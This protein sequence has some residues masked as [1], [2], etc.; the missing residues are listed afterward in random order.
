MFQDL[1]QKLDPYI[2]L[3]TCGASL[4]GLMGL[5]LVSAL[6]IIAQSSTPKVDTS[7]TVPLGSETA[8]V[9]NMSTEAVPVGNLSADDMA[10]QE[11]DKVPEV[12]EPEK[13]HE[14]PKGPIED[15]IAGLHENTPQG[16]VP[17]IRKSDGLTAY[18]AYKA[19]FEAL[20]TTK[21]LI[22]LVMV[23]YGLSTKSSELAVSSLPEG[24]TFSLSGYAADAQKWTSKARQD[25]HEVWLS[26]EMQGRSYGQD[27]TG[28]QTILVNASVDQNM[29]RLRTTLGKATGYAGVIDMNSPAFE[30][31]AADL[32]RYYKEVTSR[33]LGLA[34]ASPQDTL[35]GAYA[36]ANSVPF[37]Q[38]DMW[39]DGGSDIAAELEKLKQLSLN[40]R[41][42]IGFFHP[43]PA[44]IEA[45]NKWQ[46]DLEAA[47]IQFAPLT[48]AIDQK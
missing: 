3:K 16:M 28:N 44:V 37:I 43:Y 38:N 20:A 41:V 34:Q 30:N 6:A 42:A 14:K 9:D 13:V 36:I 15:A 31:N 45:I 19:N 21:S 46:K 27:D 47:N 39:I 1:K 22:S 26:I 40:G 8:T 10:A 23:D 17:V 33:G 24:I 32:D 25:G 48:A 4:A 11:P 7:I 29:T 2:S 5:S 35:T 18:K 12:N